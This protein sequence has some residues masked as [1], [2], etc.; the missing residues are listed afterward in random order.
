MPSTLKEADIRPGDLF[1]RYLALARR[2]IDTFFHDLSEFVTAP[3]PACGERRYRHEFQKHGFQ[4][5][6]CECCGTLYLNPRPRAELIARYY[7]ESEAVRFWSESFYPATAE[8]RREKLFRPRAELAAEWARTLGL[9]GSSILLDVG[10]G[11]GL[12]LEEAAKLGVFARHVGV[13]PGASLANACRSRGIEIVEAAVEDVPAHT[14]RADL[15]ANFE[16][17]EHVFD[18]CGFLRAIAEQ[19]SPGGTLILTTLTC[20]G[21]DIQELWAHSKSVHPPHHINLIS[22]EGMRRLFD[23]AGYD[24]VELTTP[25]LLDVSI[26]EN[27]L[28]DHPEIELSR[29]A[30]QIIESDAECKAAFQGFLRENRLSS[31]VRVVARPRGGSA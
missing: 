15:A 31:H 1:D 22:V 20:S 7:R 12:F 6:T 11:Y 19:L 21:F 26:V 23:R 3:C 9:N 28:A 5:A 25:G 8:A 10:P 16:V 17:L 13:E 14:I 2:D 4:Y 24:V 30:R 29:F 27:A 18:P